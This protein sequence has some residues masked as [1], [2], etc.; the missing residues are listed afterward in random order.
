MRATGA[1]TLILDEVHKIK[2]PN[3]IT[4]RSAMTARAMARN[5]IGLTGSVVSNRPGDLAPLLNVT[6]GYPVAGTPTEFDRRYVKTIGTRQS[7][8]FGGHKKVKVL[9]RNREIR[10]RF[11][12]MVHF[13]GHD[14]LDPELFPSKRASSVD[15]EMSEEQQELYQYALGNVSPWVRSRIQ[16]GLPVGQKEAQFVFTKILQAR[17]AA[18]SIHV[19]KNDVTL[20]Q[21][22]ER[23]PKIKK[24][25]DDA[26][27]HL[28]V[29]P[30]GQVVLYSNLVR[31]GIDVLAA[32]LQ[33]RGIPF[34]VF[35]G[36]GREVAGQKIDEVTRQ[37][38]VTD[39]L[40]GKN[41]AI[42]VS[43][44]GAEGL[45]LKNT[46]MVQMVDGHFNPEVIQ[47]AEARG[48]R[49][50]GL[51]HRPQERRFVVVKR[52]RSVMPRQSFLKRMFGIDKERTTDEW[53]YRTAKTKDTL[54]EQLRRALKGAPPRPVPLPQDFKPKAHRPRKY[55]S[56]R[57]VWTV[58]G[59]E[60]RYEY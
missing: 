51:S 23:T 27:N 10:A 48:R 40:D 59:P 33:Q 22:A 26:E 21:A 53:I 47:Q 50:K 37:Q 54:N 16:K 57:R 3:S 1:D 18:N 24:V 52:Y 43:G 4:Y 45:D 11:G 41:K 15:V 34:G 35:A 19:H 5:F 39:Y 2:D 8:I 31:G 17:Q 44:A 30:D 56:R 6:E 36:K 46:T 49:V 38:A 42:V 12:D 55:K 7:G 32:G 29:T 58:K 14:D 60:W 13:V 25:L 28:K 20:E 9:T